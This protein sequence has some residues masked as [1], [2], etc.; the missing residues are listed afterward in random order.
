VEINLLMNPV[1][2]AM[3]PVT[4]LKL[5]VAFLLGGLPALEEEDVRG[6]L[7]FLPSLIHVDSLP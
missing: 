6:H 4:A 3:R 1:V 7:T 5:V 2:F